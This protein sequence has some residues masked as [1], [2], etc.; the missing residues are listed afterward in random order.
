MILE[1]TLLIKNHGNA[2]H[3]DV[4]VEYEYVPIGEADWTKMVKI[5]LD[6]DRVA[7]DW[8]RGIID[9]HLNKETGTDDK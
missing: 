7:V 8:L 3:K 9:Q 5:K 4:V 6:G 2:Y 1:F